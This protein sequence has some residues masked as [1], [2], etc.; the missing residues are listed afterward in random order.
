VFH[1]TSISQVA[2][3]FNRYNSTKVLV[4]DLP[5]GGMQLIGRQWGAMKIHSDFFSLT[6]ATIRYGSSTGPDFNASSVSSS[7]GSGGS[8]SNC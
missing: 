5:H 8:D 6:V 3:E 2:T 4:E 7:S 1:N